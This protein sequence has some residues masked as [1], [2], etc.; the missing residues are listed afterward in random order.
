M[1]PWSLKHCIFAY[2]TYVKNGESRVCGGRGDGVK[3]SET[4]RLCCETPYTWKI[5]DCVKNIQELGEETLVKVEANCRNRLQT[6][7]HENGHHLS[8]KV[9]HSQ[10]FHNG[11]V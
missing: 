8:D 5:E 4:T 9:F 10:V 6:F 11:I 1:L 2:D 3:I 7:A